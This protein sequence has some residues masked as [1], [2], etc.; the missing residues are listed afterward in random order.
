MKHAY[1][2]GTFKNLRI[3]WELYFMFCTYFNLQELPAKVET[4]CLYVQFLRRSF[5][6]VQSIRNYLSGVKS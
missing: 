4:L 2:A 5:K 3:Q 6:S 1:A